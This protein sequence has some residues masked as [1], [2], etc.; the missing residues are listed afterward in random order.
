ML[1][2]LAS[3]LSNMWERKRGK[4]E[5]PEGHFISH[6]KAKKTRETTNK[7]TMGDRAGTGR[8]TFAIALDVIN[9][10]PTSA[11][12]S[13]LTQSLLWGGMEKKYRKHRGIFLFIKYWLLI[14][15]I[16]MKFVFLKQISN[17]IFQLLSRVLIICR[18]SIMRSGLSFKS[19]PTTFHM[20]NKEII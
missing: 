15:A 20:K 3:A 13:T 4:M 11:K 12:T 6:A 14:W 9:Y 16:W 8:L 19:K 1:H 7:L 2:L 17:N 10:F 18:V 5:W